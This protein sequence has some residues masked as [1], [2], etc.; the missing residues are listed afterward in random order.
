MYFIIFFRDI[1]QLKVSWE[2]TKAKSEWLTNI[3]PSRKIPYY[4][5]PESI[6]FED[7]QRFCETRQP[8]RT[9]YDID[10]ILRRDYGLRV[11]QPIQMCRISRG[12]T[13]D[14]DLWLLFEGEEQVPYATFSVRQ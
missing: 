5:Y 10:D 4:I 1:P 6:T 3:R 7:I 12:V 9:R 14:D 13:M 8:P 11:Y 2:G